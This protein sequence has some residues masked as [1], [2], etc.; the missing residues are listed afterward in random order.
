MKFISLKKIYEKMSN[1]FSKKSRREFYIGPPFEIF[2]RRRLHP[3]CTPPCETLLITV[4][5]YKNFLIFSAKIADN[6][7]RG[8]CRENS[9]KLFSRHLP[10]I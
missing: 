9:Y 7:F 8:K 10:S 5:E 1:S 2:S 4:I 3:T 6:Y